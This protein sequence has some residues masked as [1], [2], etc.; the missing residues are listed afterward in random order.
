[1][2][3]FWV[4]IF[5]VLGLVAC[6]DSKKIEKTGEIESKEIESNVKNNFV[7]KQDYAVS[8]EMQNFPIYEI[9][10]LI[11]NLMLDVNQTYFEWSHLANDEH[12]Q[13]QTDGYNEQYNSHTHS[14]M[15]RREGLVRIHVLGERV[16]ILRDRNYEAPWEINYYGAQ[17]NM[18]VTSIDI[19]PTGDFQTF[20]DLTPSMKKQ[21]IDVN[22]IC[23]QAYAGERT[24]VYVL[25][26]KQKQKLFLID[27]TS[28]G[29]AGS[30]QWITLEM[31]D[32]STEWCADDGLKAQI[33]D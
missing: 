17:A 16:A 5:L 14:T 8:P 18:G 13:W 19:T 32:K 24:T 23:E 15:T 29:S 12:I 30:S 6:Q 20:P 1:M 4:G 21:N 26:A 11:K 7:F 9:G 33:E 2:K 3:R 10:E 22:K 27:Q 31:Q 25:Q 28:T